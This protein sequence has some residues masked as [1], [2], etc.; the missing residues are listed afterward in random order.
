MTG[1]GQA[2]GIIV[3]MTGMPWPKFLLLAEVDAALWVGVWTTADDVAGRHTG[4]IYPIITRYGTYELAAAALVATVLLVRLSAR[5]LFMFMRGC[6][7]GQQ[8]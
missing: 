3:G 2:N 5:R 7:C 4:T 1:L 8:V 6:H